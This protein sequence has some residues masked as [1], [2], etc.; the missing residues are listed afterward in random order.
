MLGLAWD[1]IVRRG[2]PADL[3]ITS[4]T[5][6]SELLARSPQRRVLRGGQWLPAPPTQQPSPALARLDASTLR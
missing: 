3:V 4:A 6:W 1:G 2:S 5:S